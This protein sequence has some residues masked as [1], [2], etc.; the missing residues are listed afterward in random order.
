MFSSELRQKWLGIAESLKPKLNTCQ[1][2]PIRVVEAQRDERAFQGWKAMG[3]PNGSSEVTA[4]TAKRWGR[5]ESFILDFG[6]YQVGYLAFNLSATGPVDAPARLS[7]TFAETIAE[8]AEPFDPYRGVLGRGWLQDEVFNIE[9]LPRRVLIERR[10]AFRYVKVVVVDTSP[11]FLLRF[12]DFSCETVSSA[13]WRQACPLTSLLPQG[14]LLSEDFLRMDEVSL[15]TLACC[16]QT[17]FEDGPKRDRRLWLGDLRLQALVNYESFK[18]YSLVKRCL[19]LLAALAHRED[20]ALP[21]CILEHPTP[22][23]GADHILDYA[24]LF[25]NILLEYAEASGDWETAKDLWPI[26]RHQADILRRYVDDRWLFIDPGSWWIFIDWKDGLQKQTA[27]HGVSIC[28]FQATASLAQHLGYTAEEQQLSAWADKMR[29]AARRHLLCP[30]KKLFFSTPDAG[31]TDASQI[32]WASQAWMILAKVVEGDCAMDVMR[33][34]L[35]C[36]DAIRP[37]GPYLWHYVIEAMLSAGMKAE[38]VSLMRDYW[39]GMLAR[40]ADTFWEV[41]DP[42][43]PY[44]SPYKNH[45]MNSYC[46]AWSCTPAWFIR[47]NLSL[48]SR[49]AALPASDDRRLITV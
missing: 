13:D 23:P 18:N 36:P 9:T 12:S 15:R 27:M 2:A 10:C 14:E 32:S 49:P 24:A 19:Y 42:D 41:Y 20:G 16:M 38:A 43:Q 35:N 46:H 28:G 8:A 29:I 3:L 26:A 21:A 6:N 25:A 31:A 34:L 44:L 37:A 22:Q 33:T 45:I 1:V 4:I 48:F 40:G 47:R 5:G 39:G 17:V 11:S 30:Q 7:L